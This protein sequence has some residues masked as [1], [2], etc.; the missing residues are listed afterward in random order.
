MYIFVHISIGA[1]SWKHIPGTWMHNKWPL[2]LEEV[3]ATWDLPQN[4]QIPDSGMLGGLALGV[5]KASH[6]SNVQ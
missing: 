3:A 1:I 5:F 4:S 2:G 6:V